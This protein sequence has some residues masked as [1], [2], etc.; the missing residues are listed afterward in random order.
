[1]CALFIINEGLTFCA[2]YCVMEEVSSIQF[3]FFCSNC[4]LSKGWTQLDFCEDSLIIVIHKLTLQLKMNKRIFFFESNMIPFIIHER[5]LEM[6][7]FLLF[8]AVYSF[9]GHCIKMSLLSPWPVVRLEKHICMD[10]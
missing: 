2:I 4:F 3:L 8:I 6:I 10:V 7:K 5:A 9:P 1:V